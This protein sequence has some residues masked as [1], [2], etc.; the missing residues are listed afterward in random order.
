MRASR[1]FLATS[2]ALL[3]G[4]DP[5][6]STTV[7]AFGGTFTFTS[8]GAVSASFS[9]NGDRP[10]TQT[11][12]ETQA[13]SHA[14]PTVNSEVI[15]TSAQPGS[16]A[17]HSYVEAWIARNTAGTA[18]IDPNCVFNC[19]G[20]YVEFNVTNGGPPVGTQSCYLTSGAFIITSISATN[21]S[22][23]FSGT[24]VCSSPGGPT[25]SWTVTNGTFNIAINT[26][27]MYP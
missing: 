11:A 25:T 7:N 24:G 13:W 1:L 12:R 6:G 15:L 26:A 8:A 17:T 16:G 20:L 3:S 22:G 9:A 19:T 14:Q 21:V 18:T 10:S 23:T 5:S 4:C 27:S 2:L